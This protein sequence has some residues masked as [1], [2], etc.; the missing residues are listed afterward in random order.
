ML[1]DYS[2]TLA[3]GWEL[4]SKT[5]PRKNYYLI[6]CRAC[7]DTYE[8][9]KYQLKKVECWSCWLIQRVTDKPQTWPRL[10]AI[11]GA[12]PKPGSEVGELERLYEL[13][14]TRATV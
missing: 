7:G 12:M 13:E 14:D 9:I 5:T 6:R 11:I 8:R 3:P 1:R 2:Q 10:A 4:V